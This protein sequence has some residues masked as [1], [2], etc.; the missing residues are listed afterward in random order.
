FPGVDADAPGPTHRLLGD[1]DQRQAADGQDDPDGLG[2]GSHEGS[3]AVQRACEVDH[4]PDEERGVGEREQG[5]DHGVD[6]GGGPEPPVAGPQATHDERAHGS[7]RDVENPHDEGDDGHGSCN[8]RS[9]P[10]AR[11]DGDVEGFPV[12]F[13]DRVDE[14]DDAVFYAPPRFVTHIDDEAIAAVGELYEELGVKGDVLDLMSSWVSHFRTP[15]AHLRV[16]GMNEAE[17]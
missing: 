13:F 2:D 15:P 9:T 5:G 6:T 12:G 1:D 17:L 4:R 10:M 14:G 3:D 16:L 11:H 8:L 7:Q